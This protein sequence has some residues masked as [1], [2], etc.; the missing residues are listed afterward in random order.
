[1]DDQNDLLRSGRGEGK[2]KL[3]SSLSDVDRFVVEV[4]LDEAFYEI[5]DDSFAGWC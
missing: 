2:P 5:E 1:V 4:S 3:G